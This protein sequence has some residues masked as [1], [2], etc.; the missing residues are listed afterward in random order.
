MSDD[1]GSPVDGYDGILPRD[2]KGLPTEDWWHL[3]VQMKPS[4]VE[5]FTERNSDL[6]AYVASTVFGY[7]TKMRQQRQPGLYWY[8]GSSYDDCKRTW[9][10]AL[11]LS[12]FEREGIARAKIVGPGEKEAEWVYDIN[13]MPLEQ[14]KRRSD[15]WWYSYRLRYVRIEE[16][17]SDSG[18]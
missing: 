15:A 8:P 7:P 12:F 5:D 1:I 3:V 10:Y 2:L 17:G 16:A 18:I 14:A 6:C 9:M 13:A 4:H 11:Q